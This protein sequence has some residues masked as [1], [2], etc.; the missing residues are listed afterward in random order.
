MEP[1]SMKNPDPDTLVPDPQVQR[2]FSVTAM[3]MSRWDADPKMNELGWPVP[4]R[5]RKRK[6]RSRHALEAFKDKMARR[7]IAERNKHHP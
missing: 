6:F 5:I 1:Q 3:T 2:E 4:I 7:A